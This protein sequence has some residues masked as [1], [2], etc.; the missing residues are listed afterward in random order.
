MFITLDEDSLKLPELSLEL[1]FAI[2]LLLPVKSLIRFKS[3]CKS[4]LAMISDPQFAKKHLSLLTKD[5]TIDPWRIMIRYPYHDLK[6]CSLHSIFHEPYGYAVDLDFPLKRLR[7]DVVIVGSCDGLVC[8]SFSEGQI[9]ILYIWNPSTRES[10]ILPSFGK[11]LNRGISYGFGYDSSN[12]D[13]K[14]VRVAFVNGPHEV[15]VYSLRTDSWRRIQDFPND[16]IEYNCMESGQ[17]VNGSLNWASAN[18]SNH[19]WVITGFDLGEETYREIPQPDYGKKVFGLSVRALR[20]CLCAVCDFAFTIAEFWVMK[21]YGVKE[22]WTKLVTI[23]YWRMQKPVCC[24]GP[25]WYLKDG[26][27]LVDFTGEFVLYDLAEHTFNHRPIY[28]I[29][30]FHQAEIYL[31]SLVSPNAFMKVP[32]DLNE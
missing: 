10:H 15:K 4:W 12:D 28:G 1:I 9:D 8:I 20:G 22:S 2:L 14:V 19:S 21:E 31:E 23:P 7:R 24:S 6:S 16:L 13:Y 17:L 32:I 3:V 18:P 11:G 26:R 30:D 27:I 5:D 25:L 29:H